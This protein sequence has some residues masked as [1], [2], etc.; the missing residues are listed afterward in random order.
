MKARSCLVVVLA[1]GEGTRMRSSRPKVLHAITGRSLLC[2]VLTAVADF[3]AAST[4]VVVG[5]GRDVIAAE[6]KRML[7]R[8]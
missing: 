2:H 7:P 3:G 1:A 4:A 6:A 8:V 5:P